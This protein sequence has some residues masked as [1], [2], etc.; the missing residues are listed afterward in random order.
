LEQVISTLGDRYGLVLVLLLGIL[1][2]GGVLDQVRI[3]PTLDRAVGG[4]LSPGSPDGG[5]RDQLTHPG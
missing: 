1:R 2:R 3:A 5:A 4:R